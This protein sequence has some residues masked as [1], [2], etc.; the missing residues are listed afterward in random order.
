MGNG[1]FATVQDPFT[2]ILRG[3]IKTMTP[4]EPTPEQLEAV[5]EYVDENGN[6]L[7]EDDEIIIMMGRY[8]QTQEDLLTKYGRAK[9][10]MLKKKSLTPGIDL[11]DCI[12]RY[13]KLR[14]RK[15]LYRI[16]DESP[17]T[18]IEILKQLFGLT[19]QQHMTRVI[20]IARSST[21]LFAPWNISHKVRNPKKGAAS[22]AA[23]NNVAEALD[24]NWKDFDD[25]KIKDAFRMVKFASVNDNYSKEA[26]LKLI[27]GTLRT[28]GRTK[29]LGLPKQTLSK[30]ETE[31]YEQ[32]RNSM[33]D[34]MRNESPYE[35]GTIVEVFSATHNNWVLGEVIGAKSDHAVLVRYLNQ[36]KFLNPSDES[37]FRVIEKIVGTPYGIGFLQKVRHNDSFCE[38]RQAWGN[39]Y[40]HMRQIQTIKVQSIHLLEHLV[41]KRQ[42]VNGNL[43]VK[44]VKC[45]E[46][47]KLDIAGA[48]D[49]WVKI[50]VPPSGR[51]QA[52]EENI[53]K[54]TK[55]IRRNQN[56]IF[57]Q[58]L[59]FKT[60]SFT[61]TET[62]KGKVE[63][64]DADEGA[65]ELAGCAYFKLPTRNDAVE[66]II[67][68]LR[69]PDGTHRGV[70]VLQTT[71]IRNELTASEKSRRRDHFANKMGEPIR[72]KKRVKRVVT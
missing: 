22:S 13:A 48:C 52:V 43:L 47:P 15:Q 72:R 67:L 31:K 24:F 33:P 60:F 50:T 28:L 54:R 21:V 34:I 61:E 9:R 44:V 19:P 39:I 55:V 59:D 49:P 63:V 16:L 65:D 17:D 32:M 46:L 42:I 53:E 27:R 56:P 5:W 51:N 70:I 25:P 20:F 30:V 11:A 69:L 71:L 68:D 23:V 40:C 38:I 41:E 14:S 1:C 58:V 57:N 37:R 4:P 66:D 62:K 35:D 29:N 64:F 6:N 8:L 2:D 26:A 3:A 45:L 36:S 12:L 10:K 18:V 7:L